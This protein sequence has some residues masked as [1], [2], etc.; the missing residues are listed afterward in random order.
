MLHVL[1]DALSYGQKLQQD[2]LLGQASI[3]D[4]GDS[5]AA[6]A[7]HHATIPDGEF[8][9]S[10]L[11]RLEKESLGLYV[12]EHPLS[13]I[14][15]QL[16]RRTDS[17]LAELERRREGET[18]LAGG[19]VSGMRT[20][21]TKKGEPMAFVQLEDLTGSVEVVVFNSTYAAARGLLVEDAVLVVKGRVDHKQQGETKLIALEVAAFEAV[22]ERREVRL[23]VDARS[24]PAGVIRELAGVVRD[25]PGE[26]PV[27]VDCVTS[28]GPKSY[29]FGPQFKVQPAP[30]FYAEV[31]AL[32][33]ESALA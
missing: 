17:S 15:D 6:S 26:A 13:A 30:D 21:T 24:A 18:V 9:K 23:K 12:S 28:A 8:E 10:E 3:F 2:R 14:R 5:P 32:L 27:Y 31:K 16:R 11:L 29:A 7:R 19:I 25:F 22:P 1:E 20:T 4:L 33:G